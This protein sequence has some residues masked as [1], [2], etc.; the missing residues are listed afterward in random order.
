[1]YKD[2]EQ[3][4]YAFSCDKIYAKYGKII[5]MVVSN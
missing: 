3:N 4:S 5:S 2:K 1:M